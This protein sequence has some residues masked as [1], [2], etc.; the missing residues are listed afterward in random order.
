MN[1]YKHIIWC[2]LIFLA[3]TACQKESLEDF[4]NDPLE[5]SGEPDFYLNG[6]INGVEREFVAGREG[7]FM[8]ADHDLVPGYGNTGGD[9]TV[10]SKGVSLIGE[11]SQEEECADCHEAIRIRLDY[12]PQDLTQESQ[13]LAPGS[14]SYR[15]K[16][17]EEISGIPHLLSLFP[18]ISSLSETGFKYEWKLSGN[19]GVSTNRNASFQLELEPAEIVDITLTA[20][21]RHGVS[22]SVTK[23]YAGPNE[24]DMIR[25]SVMPRADGFICEAELGERF[26]LLDIEWLEDTNSFGLFHAGR[27]HY[28]FDGHRGSYKVG[29]VAEVRDAKD[30]KTK[31]VRYEAVSISGQSSGDDSDF[32]LT[33]EAHM[34]ELPV[35]GFFGPVGFI[36]Y[37]DERG[38]QYTTTSSYSGDFFEIVESEHYDHTAHGV[39]TRRVHVRFSCS[40]KDERGEEVRMEGFEGYIALGHPE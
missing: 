18:I 34:Q 11:L 37:V 3:A 36:T 8:H 15:G 23:S 9:S 27:G 28:V 35:G 1:S 4:D 40:L 26:E 30:G 17:G 39:A 5:Y 6:T 24:E 2:F 20:T 19:K 25:L 33:F 21:N 16:L 10:L 32:A 29:M 7:F 14:L 31:Q 13:V 38:N 22:H 12:P